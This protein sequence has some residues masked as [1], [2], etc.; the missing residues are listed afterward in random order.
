M[1]TVFAPLY[2]FEKKEKTGVFLKPDTGSYLRSA[3]VK[4]GTAEQRKENK[5]CQVRLLTPF[6]THVK[7][8]SWP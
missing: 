5:Y 2:H 4:M 6:S 1:R 8:P 7:Q 3:D